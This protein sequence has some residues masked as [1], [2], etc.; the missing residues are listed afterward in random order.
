MVLFQSKQQRFEI[1][2]R[3]YADMLY[4]VALSYLGNAEDAQD[5]VHDTFVKLIRHTIPF[6]DESYER[7]WLIRVTV[8]RCKDILKKRKNHLTL[9]YAEDIAESENS[10]SEVLNA[11]SGL[12]EKYKLCVQLHY[13]EGFSVEETAVTLGISVSAVKMRLSRGRQML[14]EIL[15]GEW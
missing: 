4:R 11:L 12:D 13:L 6:K 15:E 2:Y 14:K 1:A 8:N 9:E 10:S 5:A 7:A 3:D